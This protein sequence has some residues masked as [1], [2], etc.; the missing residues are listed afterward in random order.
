MDTVQGFSGSINDFL[1]RY[2]Q[3]RGF[4]HETHSHCSIADPQ[5]PPE[6]LSGDDAAA[7]LASAPSCAGH[8]SPGGPL[9]EHLLGRGRAPRR[10]QLDRPLRRSAE[11]PAAANSRDCGL[12]AAILAGRP[13]PDVDAFASQ[14]A[15]VAALDG[16]P[17]IADVSAHRAGAAALAL[18]LASR[19]T[20][21]RP[22]GNA[23]GRAAGHL[24]QSSGS[25]AGSGRIGRRRIL[26]CLGCQL[27][28]HHREP[29]S[30]LVPGA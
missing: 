10:A 18:A 23:D 17:A 14:R 1:W 28:D 3:P 5:P 8:L 25:L 7:G 24:S 30:P 6:H 21:R 22:G 16:R 2:R 4:C 27:S 19:R 9:A 11:R 20:G 29:P 12:F 13:G 15:G 26:F